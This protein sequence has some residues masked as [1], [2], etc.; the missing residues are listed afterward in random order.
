MK[1]VVPHARA[2]LTTVLFLASCSGDA[3]DSRNNPP[4]LL[5]DSLESDTLIPALIARQRALF[6]LLT[7]KKREQLTDY[8]TDDYTWSYTTHLY[9]ITRAGQPITPVSDTTSEIRRRRPIDYKEL[10]RGKSPDGLRP[11]PD[12]YKGQV[13]G[14]RAVIIAF[15]L[16]TFRRFETYWKLTGDGW[17]AE[18]TFEVISPADANDSRR[19]NN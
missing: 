6:I 18:N 16:T 4:L 17:R 9:R 10:A 7:S 12:G 15:S 3:P 11:I 19:N 2:C 5:S 14:K 13:N 1:R 8:V